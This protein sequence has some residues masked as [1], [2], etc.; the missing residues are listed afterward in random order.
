MVA[1]PTIIATPTFSQAGKLEA[2][3]L[4]FELWWMLLMGEN[5]FVIWIGGGVGGCADVTVSGSLS[6]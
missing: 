1:M 2:S 4:L 3:S 6:K 5:V